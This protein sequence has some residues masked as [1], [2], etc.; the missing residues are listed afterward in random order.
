MVYEVTIRSE[1]SGGSHH[2]E[3]LRR[4]L[5]ESFSLD[6]TP[7]ETSTSTL[8]KAYGAHKKLSLFFERDKLNELRKRYYDAFKVAFARALLKDFKDLGVSEKLIKEASSRIDRHVKEGNIDAVLKEIE[9]F[10][11]K[12]KEQN[13]DLWEQLGKPFPLDFIP[14]VNPLEDKLLPDKEKRTWTSPILRNLKRTWEVVKKFAPDDFESRLNKVL[15]VLERRSEQ[16][17]REGFP[18][19]TIMGEKVKRDLHPILGA[20]IYKFPR[21]QY[22]LPSERDMKKVEEVL[23]VLENES[24]DPKSLMEALTEL[25]ELARRGVIDPHL[26]LYQVEKRIVEERWK[27][28]RRMQFGGAG[29]IFRWEEKTYGLQK[30]KLMEEAQKKIKGIIKIYRRTTHNTREEAEREAKK[31]VEAIKKALESSGLEA[32]ETTVQLRHLRP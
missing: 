16:I 20:V 4:E 18:R 28:E 8:E 6:F 1:V 14:S 9:N 25:H 13:P 5:G 30:R 27:R 29:E 15:N 26:L 17:Q 3:K 22:I 32:V 19:G 7:S 12:V 31:A 2:V 21:E 23:R 24:A 11:I 10:V